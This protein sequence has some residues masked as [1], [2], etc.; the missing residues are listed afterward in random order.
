MNKVTR[1]AGQI[2]KFITGYICWFSA[3]VVIG[4][5]MHAVL[6]DDIWGKLSRGGA[7]GDAYYFG[8]AHFYAKHFHALSLFVL[9]GVASYALNRLVRHGL[10]PKREAYARIHHQPIGD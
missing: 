9:I 8:Q 2:I 1:A 4:T 7:V 3:F 10:R 6:L 5:A